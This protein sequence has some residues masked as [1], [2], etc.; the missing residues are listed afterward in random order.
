MFQLENTFVY[1][2]HILAISWNYFIS[3]KLPGNDQDLT[4]IREIA[5]KVETLAT[6][7]MLFVALTFTQPSHIFHTM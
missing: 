2:F 7:A 5:F 4:G 3:R 1:I 6:L